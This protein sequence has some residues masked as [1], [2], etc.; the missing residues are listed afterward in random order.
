MI[1]DWLTDRQ[2]KV[3]RFQIKP[4]KTGCK[5]AAYPSVFQLKYIRSF[6]QYSQADFATSI[7]TVLY[8]TRAHQFFMFRKHQRIAEYSVG[9]SLNM[10]NQVLKK[11]KTL[12][13]RYGKY[14]NNG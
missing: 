6:G 1:T 10:T 4:K 13:R 14:K 3:D 5:L 11:Q 12:Y 8:S 7:Q 2:E 9:N